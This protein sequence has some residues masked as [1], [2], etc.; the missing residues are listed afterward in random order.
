MDILLPIG[1]DSAPIVVFIH[2]GGFGSKDK[3]DI[4]SRFRV[5][6]RYLEAGF[7]VASIKLSLQAEDKLRTEFSSVR[8]SDKQWSQTLDCAGMA[9]ETG[10]RLDVI[11]RDGDYMSCHPVSALS[12]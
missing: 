9:T 12:K 8:D 4:E 6:V 11:Y 7:A 2:G 1:V 5:A 3:S 10:C